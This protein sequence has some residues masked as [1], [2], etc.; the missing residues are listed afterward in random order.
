M[1]Y[2]RFSEGLWPVNPQHVVNFF[3]SVKNTL[4]PWGSLGVLLTILFFLEKWETPDDIYFPTVRLKYF[5]FLG[6][7]DV[8]SQYLS[9]NFYDSTCL[10]GHLICFQ[11]MTICIVIFLLLKKRFRNL[12]NVSYRWSGDVHLNTTWNSYK[13]VYLR[14]VLHLK[15]PSALYERERVVW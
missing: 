6:V 5:E 4:S 12:L 15:C 13:Q 1:L 3:V 9:K 14:P 11:W 10:F 2:P 7:F 8:M